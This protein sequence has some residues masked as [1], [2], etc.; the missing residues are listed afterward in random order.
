MFPRGVVQRGSPNIVFRGLRRVVTADALSNGRGSECAPVP[1]QQHNLLDFDALPAIDAAAI[2]DA[3]RRA[4][5]AK[6]NKDMT[7]QNEANLSLVK[8]LA[9]LN[10]KYL[11]RKYGMDTIQLVYCLRDSK[12]LDI[13][14]YE[15]GLISSL[16]NTL[17]VATATSER[18]LM[19]AAK[20]VART[21]RKF[22]PLGFD[23]S[24]RFQVEGVP[25]DEW[26]CVD[27]GHIVLN[28]FSEEARYKYDIEHRWK[29]FQI[30]G[31]EIDWA[32]V[33]IVDED[34]PARFGDGKKRF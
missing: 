31:K 9:G 24:L 13:R 23:P 5:H 25:E 2:I 30:M 21:A 29:D 34:L 7:A 1:P 11:P 20:K 32:P 4:L 3:R 6:Y 18:H 16:C 19:A 33:P 28:L 12:L 14:M 15:V 26:M 10:A 17:V 8:R 22:N 27:M